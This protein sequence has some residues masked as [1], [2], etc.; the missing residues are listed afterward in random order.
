[1]KVA[2]WVRMAIPALLV[3]WLAARS[4]QFLV[5][6]EP[7]KSDAILVL[8]G[9]TEHRLARALDLLEK[10]YAERVIFD[11][12]AD[13]KIYGST[14]LER[15]QAWVNAQPR[16]QALT[17]CPIHGLST[18]AETAEAE[19][20]L[21]QVNAHSVLLVTSDFHTRRALSIFR[22]QDPVFTFHV[23]ASYDPTQF[24]AHWW[25][26]RQWAKTNVDEWIRLMWWECVDRWSR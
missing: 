21:R 7:A 10:G 8:A 16:S 20:C 14:Y 17:T 6:D 15:A 1:L 2:R 11:V 13:A 25:R 9:E 12:P 5:I 22:K 24:G 23:A 18:K 4:A 26:N 19:V 3:V